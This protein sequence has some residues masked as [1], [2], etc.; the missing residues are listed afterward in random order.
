MTDACL[1]AALMLAAVSCSSAAVPV[2]RAI[3]RSGT[4]AADV[5]GQDRAKDATELAPFL[6]PAR[7]GPCASRTDRPHVVPGG[8][9]GG[10]HFGRAARMIATLTTQEER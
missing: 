5:S 7:D 1:G 2:R 9:L 6:G 10:A 4:D 8:S 3:A